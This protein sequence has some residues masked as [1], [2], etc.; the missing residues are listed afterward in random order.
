MRNFDDGIVRAVTEKPMRNTDGVM[1]AYTYVY[2]TD[3][4]GR[5]V[6]RRVSL[7]TVWNTELENARNT[8]QTV[9]DNNRGLEILGDYRVNL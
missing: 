8:M 6:R 5:H 3:I 2:A 9:R 7:G 4:M 1:R